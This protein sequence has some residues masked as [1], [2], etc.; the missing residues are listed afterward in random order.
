MGDEAVEF[1]DN[2][3]SEKKRD[4]FERSTAHLDLKLEFKDESYFELPQLHREAI[5]NYYA[6]V[7]VGQ[8]GMTK[9]EALEIIAQNHLLLS[10][11]ILELEKLIASMTIRRNKLIDAYAD[12]QKTVVTKDWQ[13]NFERLFPSYSEDLWHCPR[14]GNHLAQ[15]YLKKD[16]GSGREGGL[17]IRCYN[18]GHREDA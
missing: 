11:R 16:D 9:K 1:W 2:L 5:N 4:V 3:D 15:I 17:S 13:P 6:R 14:C 8:K 10:K 7:V 18:C 12:I